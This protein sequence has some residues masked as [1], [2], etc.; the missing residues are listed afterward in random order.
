M[1]RMLSSPV[2]GGFPNPVNDFENTLDPMDQG[3]SPVRRQGPFNPPF[4]L[5][6]SS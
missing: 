2:F 5:E 4:L 3:M 6:V 1:A